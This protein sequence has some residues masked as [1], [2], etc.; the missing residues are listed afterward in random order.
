MTILTVKAANEH[1]Q[2]YACQ[3]GGDGIDFEYRQLYTEEEN[4]GA[5]TFGASVRPAEEVANEY[6]SLETAQ[7]RP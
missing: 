1:Q 3:R 4:A 5:C 6:I 7:G 2:M